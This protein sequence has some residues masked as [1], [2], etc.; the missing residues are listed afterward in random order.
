VSVQPSTGDDE[1]EALLEILP[2]VVEAARRA[3]GA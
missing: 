1:I 2:G 3:A